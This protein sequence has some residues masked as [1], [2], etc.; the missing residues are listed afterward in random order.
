MLRREAL[1]TWKQKLG[2]RAT[3]WNLHVAFD[4]AG[5]GDYRDTVESIFDSTPAAHDTCDIYVKGN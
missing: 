1:Y 4:C 5:H 2:H 3:Y